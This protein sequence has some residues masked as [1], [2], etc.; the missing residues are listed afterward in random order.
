MNDQLTARNDAS[1]GVA[2]KG[3]PVHCDPGQKLTIELKVKLVEADQKFAPLVKFT[4]IISEAKTF[5]GLGYFE[6]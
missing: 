2:L 1:F 6:L 4:Q 3:E 5:S